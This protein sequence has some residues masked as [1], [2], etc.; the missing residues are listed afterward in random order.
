M[1]VLRDRHRGGFFDCLFEPNSH[2][3]DFGI[4][5]KN[6]LFF[7]AVSIIALATASMFAQDLAP[8]IAW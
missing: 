2:L 5:M 7:G 1:I 3:S 6:G 8:R 4:T